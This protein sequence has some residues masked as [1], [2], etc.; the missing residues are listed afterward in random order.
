MCRHIISAERGVDAARV[1]MGW[2]SRIV[3]FYCSITCSI[4][5]YRKIVTSYEP[6]MAL[7]IVQAVLNGEVTCIFGCPTDASVEHE[8]SRKRFCRTLNF[9]RGDIAIRSLSRVIYLVQGGPKS[10]RCGEE[11]RILLDATILGKMVAMEQY[12]LI[13]SLRVL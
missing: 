3:T 12:T 13:L 11:G 8:T 6:K 2:V 1:S 10:V 5:M 7:I 9:G 4:K